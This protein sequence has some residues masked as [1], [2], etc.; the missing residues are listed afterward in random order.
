VPFRTPETTPQEMG[1]N[2]DG[3][4]LEI[5]VNEIIQREQ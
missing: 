4:M 2:C 3:V 1:V 5:E